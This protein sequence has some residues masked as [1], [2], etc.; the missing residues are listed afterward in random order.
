MSVHKTHCF[1]FHLFICFIVRWACLIKNKQMRV[2]NTRQV[3]HKTSD[4]SKAKEK[5]EFKRTEAVC[6][7]SDF[8]IGIVSWCLNRPFS[9]LLWWVR[10]TWFST[11][12]ISNW[13]THTRTKCINAH[14]GL[15][16][17]IQGVSLHPQQLLV[18]KLNVF[19]IS[20][21]AGC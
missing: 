21:S 12:S 8:A 11:F 4:Q 5:V 16:L 17:H 18:N 14:K 1:A 20:H 10:R 7:F 13:E 3:L 19:E 2:L 6:D 9:E 15:T